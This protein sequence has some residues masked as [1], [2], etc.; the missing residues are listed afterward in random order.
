[1]V[2]CSLYQNLGNREPTLVNH[3]QGCSCKNLSGT[4]GGRGVN[5]FG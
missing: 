2:V 4:V 5:Y 3:L 1:M